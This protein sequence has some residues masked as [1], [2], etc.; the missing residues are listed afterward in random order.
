MPISAARVALGHLYLLG[1]RHDG[2]GEQK[3]FDPRK[4]IPPDIEQR[5]PRIGDDKPPDDIQDEY[6]E[7]SR[8]EAETTSSCASAM[9]SVR[10][11]SDCGANAVCICHHTYPSAV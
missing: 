8:H 4:L 11:A 6:I 7:K 1:H 3:D 5:C 10:V 2:G 9:G